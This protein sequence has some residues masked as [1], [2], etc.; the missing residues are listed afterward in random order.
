MPAPDP[1]MLKQARLA[2]MHQNGCTPDPEA[3]AELR[4]EIKTMRIERYIR[5][6]F[7]DNES[8]P[9]TAQR[10]YLVGVILGSA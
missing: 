9:T 8:A 5:K 3:A 2:R 4:R 10:Q 7:A 1:I 6:A